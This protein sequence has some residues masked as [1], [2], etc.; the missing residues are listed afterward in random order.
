MNHIQYNFLSQVSGSTVTAVG[1]H[2][3]VSTARLA[4]SPWSLALNASGDGH[5]MDL[6]G[7][8]S[9]SGAMTA[10]VPRY[11]LEKLCIVKGLI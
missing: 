7:K 10:N 2:Y 4:P 3:T 1:G 6:G 5:W 11:W 8:G 9:M